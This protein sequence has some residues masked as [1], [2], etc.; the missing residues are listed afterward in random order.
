M[1]WLSGG[2]DIYTVYHGFPFPEKKLWNFA[3]GKAGGEDKRAEEKSRLSG[4]RSLFL[5]PPLKESTHR[6]YALWVP[7]SF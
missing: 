3:E 5:F 1:V 6:A 4:S 2:P 7:F